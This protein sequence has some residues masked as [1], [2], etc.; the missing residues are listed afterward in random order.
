[1]AFND[2]IRDVR[3]DLE[4]QRYMLVRSLELCNRL[5]EQILILREEMSR[6]KN[7]PIHRRKGYDNE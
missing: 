1:M 3:A 5:A 7:S 4:E 2:E 6:I